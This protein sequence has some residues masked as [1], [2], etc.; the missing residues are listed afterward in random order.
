LFIDEEK[1]VIEKTSSCSANAADWL[2][3]GPIGIFSLKIE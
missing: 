2:P 3:I 1:K